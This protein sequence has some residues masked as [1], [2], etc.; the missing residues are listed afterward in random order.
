MLKSLDYNPLLSEGECLG[1]FNNLMLATISPEV[2]LSSV[3]AWKLGGEG[4]NVTII[5][6]GFN[7]IAV[8]MVNEVLPMKR[9]VH[10]NLI[11]QFQS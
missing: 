6:Q 1:Y 9:I 10:S 3:S 11:G 8:N 5:I 2:S 4:G 7:Q